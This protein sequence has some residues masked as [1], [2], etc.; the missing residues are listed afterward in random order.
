MRLYRVVV[1]VLMALFLLASVFR[2]CG[3]F[4]HDIYW[5]QQH[6]GGDKATHVFAGMLITHTSQLWL[7]TPLRANRLW[8][9]AFI[10]AL[11]LSL[12]ELSQQ[13]LSKRTF[14]YED[15]G[16]SLLGLGITLLFSVWYLW[17]RPQIPQRHL[18]KPL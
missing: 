18:N 13:L 9:I 5:A 17:L 11:G 16:A 7:N 3:W 1:T 14:S 2:S 6:I 15:L 12:D 8:G 4:I 10:T